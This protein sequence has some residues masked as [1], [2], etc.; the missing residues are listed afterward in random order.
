MVAIHKEAVNYDNNFAPFGALFWL[1]LVVTFGARTPAGALYGAAAFALDE[2]D[3][4]R[5]H[6]LRLDPA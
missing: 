2:Q 3:L 5:G 1:V 4:P 6:V